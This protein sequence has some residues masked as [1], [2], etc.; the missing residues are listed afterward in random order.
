MI[1]EFHIRR[2]TATNLS[3]KNHMVFH[4]R[5]SGLS[6][7]GLGSYI[8]NI[9]RNIA[10]RYGWQSEK[11]ALLTVS[12]HSTLEIKKSYGVADQ[13]EVITSVLQRGT[14]S[15]PSTCIRIPKEE[16]AKL[17]WLV[18]DSIILASSEVGSITCQRW[19]DV[20][21]LFRWLIKTGGENDKRMLTRNAYRDLW[22]GQENFEH[23]LRQEQETKYLEKL[24]K[25]RNLS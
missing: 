19:K 11:S 14:K 8:L 3:R 13:N 10:T 25:L 1:Q 21:R 15:N 24:A 12:L 6:K 16:V 5:H 2:L 7:R 23:L 18:G 4:V 9:P 20:K 17:G 22:L